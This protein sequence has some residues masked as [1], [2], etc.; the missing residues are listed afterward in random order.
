MPQLH[1][2]GNRSMKDEA[3]VLVNH[4]PNEAT[5]DDLKYQTYVRQAIEA[6]LPDTDAGRTMSVQEVLDS[7]FQP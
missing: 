5:W 1:S 7:S 2:K 6:G 4:L 3:K